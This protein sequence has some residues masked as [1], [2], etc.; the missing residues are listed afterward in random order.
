MT[1]NE[2]KN[3]KYNNFLR[4]RGRRKSVVEYGVQV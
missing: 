2:K 4:V 3:K 1:L